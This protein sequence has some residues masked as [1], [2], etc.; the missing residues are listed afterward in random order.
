MTDVF[1][2]YS[3]NDRPKVTRLVEELAEQGFKLWFD[4]EQ[5]LPGDDLVEKMAEGISKCKS[6]VVCL[7]PSFEKK[8]PLSWV[9]ME[10][11]MAIIKEHREQKRSV[12]PVR[13]KKGGAIPTEIGEKAYADLTTSKRWKKNFPRLCKALKANDH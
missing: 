7:S 8:P 10:F 9:R 5:I 3:S 4:Q 13:I 2:S 6:F 1:I 12:I 11:K